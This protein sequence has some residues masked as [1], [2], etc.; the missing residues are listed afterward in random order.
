MSS[1]VEE[2]GVVEGFLMVIVMPICTLALIIGVLSNAVGVLYPLVIGTV[3]VFILEGIQGTPIQYS[4]NC[5][6]WLITI[7]VCAF[8]ALIAGSFESLIFCV[9]AMGLIGLLIYSAKREE[10]KK[11]REREKFIRLIK[12]SAKREEAKKARERE[13]FERAQKEKGLVKFV[14]H[15]GEERWGEPEQVKRWKELDIGLSNNFAD[16]T[17]REFEKF[18]CELFRKMGYNAESTPST[19]DYGVDVVAQKDGNTVAIQVKKY[20]EGNNVGAQTIQQTLGAMWKVKADQS[21]L[22]TTSGF[23]VYAQEQAREAPIELWDKRT[24][25]E[26]VRK[27]MMRD[28]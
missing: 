13:D 22:I 9:L 25:H 24:L 12:Y 17:P 18:V 7:A 5:L 23:T 3:T 27:Y 2:G 15:N 26:I 28:F 16:Y 11:A 21:I 14:S 1:V 4:G 6:L 19:G 10:A 20:K 8:I